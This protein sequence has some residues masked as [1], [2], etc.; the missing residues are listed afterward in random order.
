M[1]FRIYHKFI[2]KSEYEVLEYIGVFDCFKELLL[3][4]NMFKPGKYLN[5]IRNQPNNT[6]WF[7]FIGDRDPIG[8]H[9]FQ[10]SSSRFP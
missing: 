8:C 2:T 3:L 9:C 1:N 5:S 7:L 4:L 10:Q 6:I